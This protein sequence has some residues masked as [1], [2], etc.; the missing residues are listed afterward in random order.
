MF[1]SISR[2]RRRQL[3]TGPFLRKSRMVVSMMT[4]LGWAV[5]VL[6]LLPEQLGVPLLTLT[7]GLPDLAYTLLVSGIV[8]LLGG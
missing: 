3:P 2:L 1:H 6:I 7:Q 8:A 4:N 5:L